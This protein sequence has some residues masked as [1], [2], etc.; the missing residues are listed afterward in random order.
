[1]TV[2]NH[3]TQDVPG[4]GDSGKQSQPLESNTQTQTGKDSSTRKLRY[5]FVGTQSHATSVG[6]ENGM[7]VDIE[8][9]FQA[10]HKGDF[11]K[12]LGWMIKN[13]KDI[14]IRE[15]FARE[16]VDVDLPMN[17]D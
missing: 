6:V 8:E 2:N 7:V 12:F 4:A 10:F 3:Q 15:Q 11:T 1:M 16:L 5:F 9:R 14:I 17:N 13:F